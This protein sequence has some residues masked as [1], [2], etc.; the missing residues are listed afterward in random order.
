MPVL[1]KVK[2]IERKYSDGR[3]DP[4]N[5]KWYANA[6]IVNTVSTDKIAERIEEKCSLT[7]S[8][9]KG[10]IEALI[11]EIKTQLQNSYAVKLDGLGTFKMS[12]RS[13]GAESLEEF[14]VQKNIVGTRVLFLPTK[15]KDTASGKVISVLTYGTKCTR[16]PE[17]IVKESAA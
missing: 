9:V 17:N 8:D 15:Q 10:C 5:N 13:K 16:V 11:Y 12:L 6:V 4:A 3:V 1:Y 7:K 2:K 14:S